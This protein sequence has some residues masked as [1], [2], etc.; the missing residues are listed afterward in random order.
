MDKKNSKN[1]FWKLGGW[2][3]GQAKYKKCYP[4]FGSERS[5]RSADVVSLWVVG[6]VGLSVGPHYAL[7]LF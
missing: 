5:L 1:M 7:Q 3:G 4:F 6:S 2:F